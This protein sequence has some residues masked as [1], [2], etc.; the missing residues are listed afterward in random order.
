MH[1][2]TWV[3]SK[4]WMFSRPWTELREAPETLAFGGFLWLPPPPP[5][6]SK[7]GMRLSCT[8]VTLAEKTDPVKV[9]LALLPQTLAPPQ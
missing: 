9:C 5:P 2:F 1:P 4:T 3:S 6:P 7:E 8:F